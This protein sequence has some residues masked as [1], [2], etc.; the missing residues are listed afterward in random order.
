MR[1]SV[2][3]LPLLFLSLSLTLSLLLSCVSFVFTLFHFYKMP[4]FS[5]LTSLCNVQTNGVCLKKVS[6]RF[7]FKK[8]LKLKRVSSKLFL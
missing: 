3:F 7:N 2:R 6:F 5:I 4:F 1:V 8:L